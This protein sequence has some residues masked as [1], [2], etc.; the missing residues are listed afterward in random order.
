MNMTPLTIFSVYHKPYALPECDFIQPIWVGNKVGEIK[1]GFISDAT[2][3]DNIAFKN[4]NFAELTALYWIWRN[5]DII[6]S[7]YIGLSHYRRNFTLPL[8][9][10][11]KR[12]FK[13]K[14]IEDP[15][16]IYNYPL[17]EHSLQ[18]IASEE[19]KKQLVQALSENKVVVPKKS[20]LA[21]NDKQVLSIRDQ[22]IYQHIKED[23]LLLE[24]T[25]RLRYPEYNDLVATYF[26]NNYSMHC[27]NMFIGNREFID[28]YCTW[29]FPLLFDVED[30]IKISNYPYQQKVFG[31]FAE[32]LLNLYLIRNNYQLA[33]FPIL[34]FT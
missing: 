27:Y 29:L 15:S 19:L 4:D 28:Q 31:F 9:K 5:L 10:E 22:Y 13:T 2:G 21:I 26:N 7:E 6:P 17:S 23:W 18:R 3:K 30:K 11:E 32:R 8:I 34:F 14:S 16:D 12:L 25:I 1:L 33:E 20:I 24:E